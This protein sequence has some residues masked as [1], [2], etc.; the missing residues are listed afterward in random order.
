MATKA[1]TWA[2]VHDP[3]PRSYLHDSASTLGGPQAAQPPARSQADSG[4]T[5]AA[6][7]TLGGPRGCSIVWPRGWDQA[8]SRLRDREFCANSAESRPRVWR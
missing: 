5:S 2:A 6:C 7:A 4:R 8:A 3:E 1:K